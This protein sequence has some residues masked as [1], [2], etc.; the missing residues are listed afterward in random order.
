MN[1]LHQSSTIYGHLSRLTKDVFNIS[2]YMV[3]SDRMIGSCG[4]R[5]DL[6]G[7]SFVLIMRHYLGSFLK[8][9]R[10]LREIS[11]GQTDCKPRF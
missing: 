7:E 8:R 3:N 1:T 11:V 10:K 6:E 4:I 5:K 9:V 2:D